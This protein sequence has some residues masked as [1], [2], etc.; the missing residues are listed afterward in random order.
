MDI[1]LRR[2]G[3]VGVVCIAMAFPP[4][5][6]ATDQYAEETGES[7]VT[8]HREEIGGPLTVEGF[9]YIRNGYRYP[10]PERVLAKAGLRQNSFHRLVRFAV[11]YLHLVAAVIF[12]G[13]IFYIHI[14]VRPSRLTGG[15][16]RHE[17]ILG[18]TCMITL[19]LTGAYLSWV[20]IDRWDQFFTNTFGLMLF[21]K[22]ALFLTMVALGMFAIT[23]VHRGMQRE[24]KEGKGAS[25]SGPLTRE[26]LSQFDGSDGNPAYVVYQGRVYD[27]S[28]SDKWKEGSH[29]GKHH[30]GTDLTGALA[31]APHGPEV[32]EGIPRAGEISST[33]VYA[34]KRFSPRRIFV[35]LAYTNLV[36]VFLILGCISIW[37]WGFPWPVFR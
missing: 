26:S 28:A 31:G 27:V 34:P 1:L 23:V 3:A 7:C 15:I 17:K 6:S 33:P 12:F 13:A 5:A 36:I 8:C 11:G 16:P 37:R 35:V 30:A 22:I 24:A 18:V 25:G 32:F 14:F 2:L 9:A 4:P 19:A 21:L 10:V 29:F 20:R